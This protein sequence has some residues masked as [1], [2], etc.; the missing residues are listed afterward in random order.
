MPKTRVQCSAEIYSHV[1]SRASEKQRMSRLWA[2]VLAL[3]FQLEFRS[4][5]PLHGPLV[6]LL[7]PALLVFSPFS[8]ATRQGGL[9]VVSV[10]AHIIHN[11]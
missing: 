9:L 8:V 4:Q 7:P 5:K 2:W 6:L 11:G 1:E 10:A 3:R